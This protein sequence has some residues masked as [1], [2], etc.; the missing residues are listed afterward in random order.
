MDKE[1]Q[2][3]LSAFMRSELES[4]YLSGKS[5]RDFCMDKPY[6]FHKLNYW[7]LK[8][9]REQNKILGE[10]TGF[11]S[12]KPA[13]SVGIS[14][15]AKAEIVFPNGIRVNIYESVTAS[16]IKSLL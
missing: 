10:N 4:F 15:V 11:V 12:L 3:G 6:T 1:K 14:T 9:N 13:D 2:A 16:F 7:K 5:V 8:V